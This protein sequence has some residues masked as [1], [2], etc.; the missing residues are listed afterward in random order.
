M[1]GQSI[2]D[3]EPHVPVFKKRY[4]GPLTSIVFVLR[5]WEE[6]FKDET[7]TKGHGQEITSFLGN[8]VSD[9]ISISDS[10]QDEANRRAKEKMK[11]DAFPAGCNSQHHSF[12]LSGLPGRR[13]FQI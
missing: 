10:W 4:I 6:T 2:L 9:V 8:E 12:L 1:L 5:K 3:L 13:E 11:S 7:Q